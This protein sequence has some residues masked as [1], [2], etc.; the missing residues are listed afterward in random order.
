[1]EKY[2]LELD[3]KEAVMLGAI[4]LH[5]KLYKTSYEPLKGLCN[6]VDSICKDIQKTRKND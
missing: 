6:K 3:R 4:V 5:Q 2:I 1:M